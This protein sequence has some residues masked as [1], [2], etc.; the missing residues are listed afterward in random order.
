MSLVIK[1]WLRLFW[2]W[3]NRKLLSLLGRSLIPH[4]REELSEDQGESLRRLYDGI[5]PEAVCFSDR[6]L[7]E[8]LKDLGGVLMLVFEDGKRAALSRALLERI[9]EGTRIHLVNAGRAFGFRLRMKVRAPPAPS[10][11]ILVPSAAGGIKIEAS[12]Y[13]G[14]EEEKIVSFLRSATTKH[15]ES[16]LREEQDEAYQRSLLSDKNKKTKSETSSSSPSFLRVA[17]ELPEEPSQGGLLLAF[18]LPDGVCKRRFAKTDRLSSLYDYV[19]PRIGVPFLLRQIDP[20]RL[21]PD[22]PH[23]ALSSYLDCNQRIIVEI[24]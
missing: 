18:Q 9:P 22:T 6:T 1:D 3:F 10:V 21:I 5:A 8:D 16:R 13:A 19:I 14:R 15:Q 24:N 11:A 12:S 7:E 4:L 23:I 2:L 17:E 20:P